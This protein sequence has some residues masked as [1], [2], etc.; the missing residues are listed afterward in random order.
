MKVLQNQSSMSMVAA[1]IVIKQDMDGYLATQKGVD[2]MEKV[3]NRKIQKNLKIQKIK[4]Q[5]KI[6]QKKVKIMKITM[7]VLHFLR[8]RL[9]SL[10]RLIQ[11]LQCQI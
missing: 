9:I 8:Y 10:I 5:N 2:H 11:Q 1:I 6:P 3:Q 4:S 7:S